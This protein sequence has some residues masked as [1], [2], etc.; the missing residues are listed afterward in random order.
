[1]SKLIHMYERT[2]GQEKHTG[3][4]ASNTAMASLKAAGRKSVECIVHNAHE[5][6]RN[7]A[8]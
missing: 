2:E 6:I 4:M 1:M 8:R 7:F 5:V 3:A